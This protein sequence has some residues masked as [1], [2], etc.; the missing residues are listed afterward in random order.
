MIS[1]LYNSTGIF[2]VSLTFLISLELRI[3]KVTAATY[4]HNTKEAE[5]VSE[6]LY[7][8]KRQRKQRIKAITLN[9]G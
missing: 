2:V 1:S 5:I 8:T 4:H 9:A 3:G 7:L 6:Q